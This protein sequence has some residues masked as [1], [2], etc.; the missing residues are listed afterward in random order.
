MGKI[1]DLFAGFRFILIRWAAERNVITQYLQLLYVCTAYTCS[2]DVVSFNVAI[3]PRIIGLLHPKFM[4]Y[5]CLISVMD[6]YGV[7]LHSMQALLRF[8]CL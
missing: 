4:E 5:S 3:F 1:V 8:Q 2:T 7:R 6:M